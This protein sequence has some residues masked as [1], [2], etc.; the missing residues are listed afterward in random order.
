MVYEKGSEKV[1]KELELIINSLKENY[2][3]SGNILY[4]DYYKILN[5]I[6]IK[7]M[8]SKKDIKKILIAFFEQGI[9]EENRNII[10]SKRIR[11]DLDLERDKINN[12]YKK[13]GI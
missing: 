2:K 11:A 4:L 7:T 3:D 12:D 13:V 9:L 5:E 1:K 8:V 6:Y 10:L